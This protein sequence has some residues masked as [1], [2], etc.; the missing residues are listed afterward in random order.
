[1]LSTQV[2][3][4]LTYGYRMLDLRPTIEDADRLIA[5]KDC[6]KE[7]GI[8]ITTD[9]YNRVLVLNRCDRRK[10]AISISV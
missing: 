5:L 6:C 3:Q 9:E 8:I 2:A 4:G 7:L 1:M 10:L